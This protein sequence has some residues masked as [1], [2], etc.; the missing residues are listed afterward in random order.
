LEGSVRKADT[1]VRVTAQLVDATTDRHIWAERYDRNLHDIF[2]LQDE[3]VRKIVTTLKLQLTLQEQGV[4]VR[5][6]TDNLEAYDY[7]LRGAD[8]YWQGTQ[9]ANTQARQMFEKAVALDPQYALAYVSMGW[10]YLM[11]WIAQ[12][13][14]D[15]QTL[16]RASE[17]AQKALALDEALP[18]P[19]GI[20]NQIYLQKRQH[21]QAI[22]EAERAL[23]LDPNWADGYVYQA[24]TLRFSGRAEEAVELAK[25]AMRLNPRYPPFYQYALGF[26]YCQVGRYKD[27]LTAQQEALARNP[28]SLFVHV[29][30]AACYSMAGR[31]EEARTQV[32]EIL[33]IS[34]NFSLAAVGVAPYKDPA[35]G[36]A[37]LDALRKAGLK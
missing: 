9:E 23:A 36:K 22:A 10:T 12:W 26:S 28:H 17:F 18:G 13:N 2:A 21:A 27:A 33:R 30:L 6:T 15:P 1:Q 5:K 35:D 25:K 29:C 37:M 34:P 32:Q 16:E 4:L 8:Y 14:R 31:D 3:I 7:L 24:I 11:E 20:L 19:H